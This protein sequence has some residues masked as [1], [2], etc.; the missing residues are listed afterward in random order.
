MKYQCLI[1]GLELQYASLCVVGVISALSHPRKSQAEHPVVN[2]V[3][4]IEDKPPGHNH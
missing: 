3:A 4:G 2:V 1:D